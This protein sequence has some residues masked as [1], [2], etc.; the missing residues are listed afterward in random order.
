QQKD[1]YFAEAV[2]DDN[3]LKEFLKEMGYAIVDRSYEHGV[4]DAEEAAERDR[5]YDLRRRIET[6]A[7]PYVIAIAIRSTTTR[8]ITEAQL[9][10]VR[11]TMIGGDAIRYY[12]DLYAATMQDEQLKATVIDERLPN[13]DDPAFHDIETMSIADRLRL[14][15]DIEAE[16]LK[17]AILKGEEK[18]AGEAEKV[19]K[20]MDR[21]IAS[22]EDQIA[23]LEEDLTNRNR[24]LSASEREVTELYKKINEAR[25][26][27][28]KETKDLRKK[29]DA[30]PKYQIDMTNSYAL[31]T[32][33]DELHE[34]TKKLRMSDRVKATLKRQEAL[35]ELRRTLRE[36]QKLRDDARKI[37]ALKLKRARSIMGK[38]SD[39]I[40]YEYRQKIYQ[41]QSMLDPNFRTNK[42]NIIDEAT[43]KKMSIDSAAD[44]I[45]T[46]SDEE[47]LSTLGE[48]VYNR[49]KGITK[50]LND[51]SLIELEDVAETVANLRK[52][53]RLIWEAKQE[54]R[55]IVAERYQAAIT[56]SLIATGKY[57]P[58][59]LS[60]SLEDDQQRR[61]IKERLR[62]VLY[63]TWDADRWAQMLDNGHKKDAYELLIRSRRRLQQLE[64]TNVENRVQPVVD[65]MK[66]LKISP[67]ELYK[68]IEISLSGMESHNVSI[69]Y[70]MYAYL[71]QFNKQNRDAVAYGNLVSIAEKESFNN[72][73]DLVKNVGDVRYNELIAI[74]EEQL[75]AKNKN[76]PYMQIVE[77][78]RKDLNDQ[79]PRINE[80][81]I[82]EYNT[83][84]RTLENYLPNHRLGATGLELS[85][86]ILDDLYDRNAGAMPTSV[87]KGFMRDR[88]NIKPAN[89]REVNMDLFGVWD[90]SMRQHEHMIAFAE[91]GRMLNRVFKV[92]TD[93]V[94]LL[95]DTIT[96]T[97]GYSMMNNL[98][99]YINEAIN[100]A[101][102]RRVEGGDKLLRALR[103]NLGAAYLAWKF[104][105]LVLQQ[106]T[107]PMPFTADIS[108]PR[109]FMA[110]KDIMLHPVKTW[111]FII[112]RSKMMKNRSMNPI[113]QLILE[114]SQERTTS[115]LSKLNKQQQEIGSLGLTWVDRFSVM[116]GWLAAYQQELEKLQQNLDLS[117]ARRE[118]LASEYAD[119]VV[120]R[121]QP[122]GDPLELSPMFKMGGEAMKIITQFQVS[123]N[124]IWKN[125]TYDIPT[126][127]KNHEYVRAI[128]QVTG[129]VLAG[130]IL[131]AV[132][133]G[134]KPDDD[135]KKKALNWLYWSTTQFSEAVPL[136]SNQVDELMNSAITGEKPHYFGNDIYPAA[137]SIISGLTD[138]TQKNYLRA[139]KRLS[140][141]FGYSIG[142]PVSGVKQAIRAT[143]EGPGAT[144]GR[145]KE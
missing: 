13:I 21:D 64:W 37:R 134:H 88:I 114:R 123:L 132:A 77:A 96:Q 75:D 49:I 136:I 11:T 7:S 29:A 65:L 70:L 52:E 22:L 98:D 12:R 90:K 36:K 14:A 33:I 110:Y 129:Y 57:K 66:Q 51:W 126:M 47:L 50:P 128:G 35:L 139:L 6:E 145:R 56:Q 58:R 73:H 68:N 116:G 5:L 92:K 55:R 4:S 119:E 60:Q 31:Q 41:I 18:F 23:K 127:V 32:K 46:F 108:A 138:I 131:G 125:L 43:G 112:E 79:A 106:I 105:G 84:M 54:Q 143:K 9:K 97:Y 69:S 104:S 99:N 44:I 93:G 130:A 144:L 76:S 135:A 45:S 109:L 94:R 81:A 59:P 117:D 26:A 67:D 87:E 27:L 85:E 16:D 10:K 142:L 48:R 89:Q 86:S 107:S 3:K 17:R 124:V 74:A 53:G 28:E 141:G 122:T 111:E 40:D 82:R 113:I 78:I 38:P 102:F 71:S 103:G 118:I 1:D 62:A 15:A 24:K 63:A 120:L 137:T 2:S 80:I 39:A 19:I 101:S 20:K 100:P 30:D 140:E 133:E 42:V 25:S 8:E 34:Q 72:D 61:S 91:Y 95:R 115:K 83:P 121:T